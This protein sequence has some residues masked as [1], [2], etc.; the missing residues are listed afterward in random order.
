MHFPRS[1]LACNFYTELNLFVCASFRV[2]SRNF[3]VLAVFLRDNFNCS[4]GL[5]QWRGLAQTLQT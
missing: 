1:V 4:V 2:F 3:V 5:V